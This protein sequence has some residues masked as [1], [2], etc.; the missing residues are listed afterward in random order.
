MDKR[1]LIIEDDAHICSLLVD[2]LEA[3]DFKV[4]TA[5]DGLAGLELITEVQPDLIICDI[6]MPKLNGFCVLKKFR[7]D[8]K[9]SKI[10]FI[11]LTAETN[12]QSRLQ[13]MELGANEYL[14]KPI[15]IQLFLDT[16]IYQL[17]QA[18]SR[19]PIE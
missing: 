10:P 13:A 2:V 3:S 7:K 6:H 4:F 1:L 11:F 17:Q 8:V 18:D 5:R 12:P 19:T 16:V 14:L 9:T 15:D